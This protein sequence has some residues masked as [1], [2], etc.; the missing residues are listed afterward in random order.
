[1][2]VERVEEIHGPR[3]ARSS[4]FSIEPMIPSI[5]EAMPGTSTRPNFASLQSITRR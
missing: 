2:V 1:V 3:D 5:N 4:S